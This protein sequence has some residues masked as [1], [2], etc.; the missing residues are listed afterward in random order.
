L[1]PSARRP[2][3]ERLS[4]LKRNLCRSGLSDPEQACDE[5][6]RVR[7][8]RHLVAIQGAA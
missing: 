5:A 6:A 2:V 7:L 8:D 3:I 1:I 4:G